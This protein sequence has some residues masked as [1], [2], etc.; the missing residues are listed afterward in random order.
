M[1]RARLDVARP[2]KTLRQPGCVLECAEARPPPRLGARLPREPCEIV[3]IGRPRRQ[4]GGTA[5]NA[6]LIVPPH[7]AKKLC[8]APAVEQH[9]MAGPDQVVRAIGAGEQ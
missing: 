1:M 8:R 4:C 3:A 9:V 6:R 5:R 2:P 7:L